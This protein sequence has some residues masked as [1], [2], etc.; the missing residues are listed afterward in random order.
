M[1]EL[2]I[3]TRKEAIARGLKR[4]Y[5][6]KPCKRGHVAEQRVVDRCCVECHRESNRRWQSTNPEKARESV[7]RWSIVNPEKKREKDRRWHAKNREKERE[8]HRRW[9]AKNPGKARE[10]TCHWRAKNPGKMHESTRRWRAKN[11]GKMRELQRRWIAKNPGKKREYGHKRRAQ[12]RAA[13]G[14]FS[15]SDIKR[16]LDRQNNECQVCHVD[17]TNNYHVDHK[18]PLARGGN[19]NPVNLQL[20]CP[21]CNCSKHNKTMR[22]FIEFKIKTTQH[23]AAAV[24]MRPAREPTTVSFLIPI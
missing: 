18:V 20:L 9:R 8:R 21:T 14:S 6:G 5:T 10:S 11:S 23:Q 17:I 13:G 4:Y 7:R 22:E 3:I 24:I 15:A 19:N 12:K 2:E 1:S 16:L